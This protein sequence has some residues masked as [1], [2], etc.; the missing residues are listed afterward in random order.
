MLQLKDNRLELNAMSENLPGFLRG[1][2]V[3]EL[4]PIIEINC[5]KKP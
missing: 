5:Q 1:A 3:K 4:K 2:G